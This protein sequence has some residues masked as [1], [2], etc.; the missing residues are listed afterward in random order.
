MRL[1]PFSCHLKS[2]RRYIFP[3]D[4]YGKLKIVV[5]VYKGPDIT[6]EF[7]KDRVRH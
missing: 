3:R 5:A 7:V 6:V 2:Q 4:L 1:S